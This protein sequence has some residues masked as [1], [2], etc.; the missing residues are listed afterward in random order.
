MLFSFLLF[1]IHCEEQPGVYSPNGDFLPLA[2]DTLKGKALLSDYPDN[3]IPIKRFFRIID[4]Y[5]VEGDE[6]YGLQEVFGHITKLDD[7]TNFIWNF[8]SYG[9]GGRISKE[10]QVTFLHLC[11]LDQELESGKFNLAIWSKVTAENG[12]NYSVLLF[13]ETSEFY[14]VTNWKET[15]GTVVLYLFFVGVVG[16]ILYVIFSKDKA[17]KTKAPSRK[18]VAD[19]S[20]IHKASRS[21]SPANRKASPSKRNPSPGK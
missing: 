10:E 14:E 19:Y 1:L 12:M 7:S 18:E 9:I 16:G 5:T 17:T 13:N 21:S 6:N 11:E 15:I 20:V 2:K 3:K 4:S 8:T